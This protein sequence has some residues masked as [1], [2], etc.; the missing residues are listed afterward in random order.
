[1]E[2]YKWLLKRFSDETHGKECICGTVQEISSPD[3]KHDC[4]KQG[5]CKC[6]E[7]L[8]GNQDVTSSIS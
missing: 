7:K 4:G 6:S 3:I 8:F 5:G 2:K 1:M